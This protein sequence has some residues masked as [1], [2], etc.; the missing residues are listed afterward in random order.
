MEGMWRNVYYVS[1]KHDPRICKGLHS[2][3]VKTICDNW[4]VYDKSQLI[5]SRFREFVSKAI[6]VGNDN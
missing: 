2:A 1:K 4:V 5:Q 3:Q 6:I